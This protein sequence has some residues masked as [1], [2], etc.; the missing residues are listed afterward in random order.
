M[1]PE[2]AIDI[3]DS[4]IEKDKETIIDEPYTA[5]MQEV[6]VREVLNYQGCIV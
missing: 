1:Q 4:L 3:S 5:A 2:C 6:W